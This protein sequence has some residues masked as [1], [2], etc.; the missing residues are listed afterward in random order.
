M[1]DL[2]HMHV[3]VITNKRVEC[4]CGYEYDALLGAEARRLGY[5]HAQM[6]LYAR[7]DNQQDE[8][9]DGFPVD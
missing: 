2:K 4:S 7:V 5:I 6:Q 3:V 8:E 1:D 9:P